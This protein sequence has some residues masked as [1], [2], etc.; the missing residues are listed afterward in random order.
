M[1]NTYIDI[2]VIQTVPASNLNRG[3]DGKPKTCVYGGVTR[4]RV[5]SQSWKRATRLAF[6]KDTEATEDMVKSYRT[7]HG[8]TLLASEIQKLNSDMTVEDAVENAKDIFKAVGIKATQDTK[9][10]EFLTS[11][12]LFLSK[13]ELERV[14]KFATENDISTKEAKDELKKV[15]AGN[16]SVDLALFGRLVAE[17]PTLTSE[18][19]CQVAHAISTHAVIPELDYFVALDDITKANQGAAMIDNF[20]F[21]T[22]TLYRYANINFNLLAENLGNAEIA[23]KAATMFIRDFALSIPSGKQTT[24]AS[25]TVPSYLLVTIR[26]DT[27]LNLASAFEKPIV[28]NS[29]YVEKSIENLEKELDK[30]SKFVDKPELTLALSLDSDSSK[31]PQAQ[32]ID[33]FINQVKSSLAGK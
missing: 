24:F 26:D 25:K 6:A 8:V 5:S 7:K 17:S 11:S 32:N 12:L 21:D 29:G 22:A 19:A 13:K 3:E 10:G 16:Q 31:L 28:S 1:K 4:A 20:G 30:V 2:H 18:A 15:L 33:G 14:A 9:T 23:T 27:P